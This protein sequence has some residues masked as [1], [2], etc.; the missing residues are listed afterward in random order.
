MDVT[1]SSNLFQKEIKQVLQFIILNNYSHPIITYACKEL[2]IPSEQLIPKTISD[3]EEKTA[4]KEI[5]ELRIQHYEARRKAKLNLIAE[6]IIENK[7]HQRPKPKDL[8]S[9]S[10]QKSFKK[11]CSPNVSFTQEIQTDRKA[12][13]IKNEIIKRLAV[14]ENRK[15]IEKEHEK[16]KNATEQK[17]KEKEKREKLLNFNK[18][19]FEVRDKRIKERLEKKIKDIELH[20]IQALKTSSF[21]NVEAK[22]QYLSYTPRKDVEVIFNQSEDENVKEKLLIIN[23][24]LNQS[25]QRAKKYLDEKINTNSILLKKLKKVKTMR[26]EIEMKK[27]EENTKKMLKIQQSIE[28]SNV[29]NK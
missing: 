7:L 26:E 12:N 14:E 8:R 19:L 28:F 22:S 23:N 9:Q 1:I 27:E 17:I 11:D 15:R 3:L 4:T 25:A 24:R 6:F 21:Y 2:S 13:N 16:I 29:N 10:P 20:E 18:K 5:N